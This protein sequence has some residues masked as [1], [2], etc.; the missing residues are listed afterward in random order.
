[1][2]TVY[3]AHDAKHDRRVAVKVLRP[4]LAA[5]I[6]AERFLSEIR[7][8]AGLQHPHILPLFDSGAAEGLLY[9]VMPFVEGETLRERL[10][11]EQQLPVADA[12][13]IAT[14]IAD[15]LHYAHGLGV[16]H[17]DIKPENVLLRGGHAFVT[18]FGIALAV[19]TAGGHR[20]TQTG[21]SLGTPHYMAPEQA[22]G[23]R[24]VTLRA[25]VYA[26]GAITYEML[27]GEPPFSGPTAQAVLA[28]AMTDEPRSLMLLRPSVPAHVD[29]AVRTALAKVP[30]DRFSSA[31]GFANALAEPVASLAATP[32]R[33]PA[34][35]I[36]R[37]L[38]G[39]VLG[40]ALL[41]TA[42]LGWL[43]GRRTA[44]RSSDR[45][46]VRF[47]IE[48]DSTVQRF[49]N[50]AISPDGRVV[51][52]AAEGS[53]G[54]QLYARHLSDLAALPLPSTENAEAPFFSP[55]GA[56]VAFYSNGALRKVRLDGGPPVLVARLPPEAWFA[57]GTWGSDDTIHFATTPRGKLF[58]VPSDGGTPAPVAVSD[59]TMRLIGPRSLPGARA[60]LVTASPDLTAGRIAVLDI[61]DRK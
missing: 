24:A 9:Y 61:E 11:R 19:Q 39:I 31:A 49:H 53:A 45:V 56:W 38:I 59:T 44:D 23:E 51:V 54:T 12:L 47:S 16:I 22:V 7:T 26:L 42:T 13:R 48:L 10:E 29:V 36:A 57:G 52:Y 27:A 34:R 33:A 5:A 14:E 46:P 40:G 6:G 55:D 3:L 41:A 35:P 17:R 25:D 30:A 58:R 20:I 50:L 2:A 15:A 8:T 32:A 37:T 18:D 43:L 1:M 21:L 4:E 60:L 28:R